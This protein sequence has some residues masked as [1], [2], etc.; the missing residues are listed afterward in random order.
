VLWR[1]STDVCAQC[2]DE[3]ANKRLLAVH[4]QLKDSL[5]EIEAALSRAREAIPAAKLD[6]ARAADVAQRLRELDDDLKFLRVGNS[7]HNMHYADSLTR[8]LVDRLAAISRELNVPEP[9]IDL[10]EP[11]D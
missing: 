4:E 1:A 6:E 8:A 9:E 7:I 11:L 3:A 5:E 2:H 10:P